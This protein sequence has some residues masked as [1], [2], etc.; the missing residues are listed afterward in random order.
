MSIMLLEFQNHFQTDERPALCYHCCC[1]TGQQC[2]RSDSPRCKPFIISLIAPQLC[3]QLSVFQFSPSRKASIVS[4]VEQP[5]MYI[6]FGQSCS[7]VSYRALYASV[8][9]EH[10]EA[11]NSSGINILSYMWDKFPSK[12][13]CYTFESNT[14]LFCCTNPSP[15]QAILQQEPLRQGVSSIH[16]IPAIVEQTSDSV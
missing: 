2:Y 1:N 11:L 15:L 12:L 13:V 10:L 7:S 8:C 5:R 9:A 6:L 4:A 14:L 16:I 3:I